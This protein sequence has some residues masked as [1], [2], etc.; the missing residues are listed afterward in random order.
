MV[1]VVFKFDHFLHCVHSLL[2]RSCQADVVTTSHGGRCMLVLRLTKAVV[3]LWTGSFTTSLSYITPLI[4]VLL[5]GKYYCVCIAL[6]IIILRHDV[7][8]S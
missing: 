2:C 4:G 3:S 7:C 5:M 8:V 6:V 1:G